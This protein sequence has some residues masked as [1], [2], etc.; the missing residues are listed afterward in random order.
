M[1]IEFQ[2]T[3]FRSLKD[4]QTLSMVSSSDKEHRETNVI[5]QLP[6]YPL[7]SSAVVFGANAS[8][9]SNLIQAILTMRNIVMM[10][11]KETIAEEKFGLEPFIFSAKERSLPTRFEITFIL[12]KTRYQYGFSVTKL[13]VFEE[14][15][16]FYPNN[17]PSL[18]FERSRINDR[19]QWKFGSA[20]KGEKNRL[21][22]FTRPNSLFLSSGANLNN[23]QLI[24]VFNW[25]KNCLRFLLSQGHPEPTISFFE[26]S[27][28]AK[29]TIISLMQ[30]ADFGIED[31]Q[32]E[33]RPLSPEK[34]FPKGVPPE[35]RHLLQPQKGAVEIV[36]I[37]SFHKEIDSEKKIPID[38]ARES[39]G[40]QRYF[41]LLG[42]FLDV[43]SNGYTLFMD[44]LEQ[45]L[46]PIL[47]QK[48]M[49]MFHDPKT[50]TNGAQLIFTTHN[51]TLLDSKNLRRDQVWFMEKD[52]GSASHLYSLLEYKPRK[53]EALQKG[54]LEGR[55]GAIP[56]LGDFK[57]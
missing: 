33:K 15:L 54:Y 38:L 52:R 27:D 28:T 32:I 5:T 12:D 23:P 6:E 25:F 10:S 56:M 55:Y 19:Y 40:T 46:H 20:L 45:S 47:A 14:W 57:I 30:D 43:L 11:A 50:N 4:T 17:R 2:V 51:T 9:K 1:M 18:L 34:D 53:T 26:K 22:A 31:I 48:V 41:C 49:Q 39:L 13:L 21:A 3:N 42:P 16:I 36:E 44:E 7:L 24:M 37:Y 8:G 35:I 29:E